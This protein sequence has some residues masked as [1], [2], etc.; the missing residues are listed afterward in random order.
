MRRVSDRGGS[1]QGQS[2]TS[3]FRKGREERKPGLRTWVIGVV[4]CPEVGDW[5]HQSLLAYLENQ[6]VSQDS[7]V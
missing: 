4:E 5:Y 7:A 3:G 2:R 6:G 1:Q